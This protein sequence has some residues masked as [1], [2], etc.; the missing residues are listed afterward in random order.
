MPGSPARAGKRAPWAMRGD[1]QGEVSSEALRLQ[2]WLDVKD[3]CP[4]LSL[5]DELER[6]PAFHVNDGG[7]TRACG[8]PS[9]YRHT[10]CCSSEYP[11]RLCRSSWSRCEPWLAHV[12]W[13]AGGRC[14]MSLVLSLS[15][16]KWEWQ[17]PSAVEGM[18][19]ISVCFLL[20]FSFLP[21]YAFPLMHPTSPHPLSIWALIII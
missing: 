18:P 16:E 15:S 12:R 9:P 4:E 19:A 2:G 8:G 21:G 7:R 5:L 11:G 1:V 3:A 10:L 13:R 20:L 6:A 14:L 17:M